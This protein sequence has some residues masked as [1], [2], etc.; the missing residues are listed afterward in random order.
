MFKIILKRQQQEETTIT[1]TFNKQLKQTIKTI[2]VTNHPNTTI[3]I[4]IKEQKIKTNKIEQ[5]IQNL[6][7]RIGDINQSVVRIMCAEYL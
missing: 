7:R 5:I 3:F 1:T 4:I 2:R 6:I